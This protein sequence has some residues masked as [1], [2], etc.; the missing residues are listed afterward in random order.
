MFIH[1]FGFSMQQIFNLTQLILILLKTTNA[2]LPEREKEPELCELVKTYQIHSYSRK[3]WKYNENNVVFRTDVFLLI[4]QLIA[5]LLQTGKNIDEKSEIP[6][7]CLYHKM[8]ILSYIWRRSQRLVLHTTISTM[9]WKPGKQ[10]RTSK[11]K[12]FKECLPQ[13]LPGPFLNNLSH[14][15]VLII[16]KDWGP[17]PRRLLITNCIIIKQWKHLTSQ[18]ITSS[19]NWS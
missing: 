3:C 19:Q 16:F 13:I 2:E 11:L 9:D 7:Q 8:M 10:I 18:F 17:Q 4:K 12:F 1:L 14:I 5:K 15:Y 6:I